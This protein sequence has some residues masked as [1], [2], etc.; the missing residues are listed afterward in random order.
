MFTDVAY[1]HWIAIVECGGVQSCTR[2]ACGYNN[3]HVVHDGG[4]RKEVQEYDYIICLV[5]EG[6]EDAYL[7][8]LHISIKLQTPLVVIIVALLVA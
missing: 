4:S 3:E 1:R 8:K 5:I 7:Q 6:S 2:H